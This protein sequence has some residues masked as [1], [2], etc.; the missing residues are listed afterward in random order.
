[1]TKQ[2]SYEKA[3][4]YYKNEILPTRAKNVLKK[5]ERI[6]V[7]SINRKMSTKIRERIQ[8][9]EKG[10]NQMMLAHLFSAQMKFKSY[11]RI[12]HKNY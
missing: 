2:E 6:P 4:F 8:P 7:Y 9:I 10:M 3:D 11:L 12:L 1:M 5:C